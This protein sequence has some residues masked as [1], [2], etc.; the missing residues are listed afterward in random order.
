MGGQ[1]YRFETPPKPTPR[2]RVNGADVDI[3]MDHGYAVLDRVWEQGDVVEL[4]LQMPAR[5]V[6]CDQ[7][8]SENRGRA[9]I[10]RGPIVY[11]VEQQD[12]DVQLDA[13]SLGEESQLAAHEEPNLLGGVVTVRGPGFT[14]IPY[15]AWANRGIGPMRVWLGNG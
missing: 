2:L 5:K 3:E 1:L 10:Q 14:A 6:I 15:Y 7:R 13:I 12:A 11:C 4:T 8:V 9:A